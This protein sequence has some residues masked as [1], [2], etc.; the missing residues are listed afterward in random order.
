MN[1]YKRYLALAATD[2]VLTEAQIMRG[3]RGVLHKRMH[4]RAHPVEYA[5]AEQLNAC[6]RH[7]PRAITPEHAAK[8]LAWWRAMKF[9]PRG[10]VYNH[11]TGERETQWRDNALARDVPQWAREVV[12]NFDHFMFEGFEDMTS[13]A[14]EWPHLVP[15]YRVVARDGTSFVY[16]ARA[17]QSGG[18]IEIER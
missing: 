1:A 6:Y 17:W 7:R 11:E 14:Y 10:A 8:G 2:T 3:L 9:Q 16:Y 5:E 12:D 4:P 13:S 18:G 15:R